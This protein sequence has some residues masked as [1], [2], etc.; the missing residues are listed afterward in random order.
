MI[1]RHGR[2]H[3]PGRLVLHGIELRGNWC[4]LTLTERWEISD[5][6]VVVL[7]IQETGAVVVIPSSSSPKVTGLNII[8]ATVRELGFRV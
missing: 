6:Q 7:Q 8:A 3:N 4:R 1:S 5:R 2:A